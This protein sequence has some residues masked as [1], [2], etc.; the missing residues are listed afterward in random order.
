MP[1]KVFIKRHIRKAMSN[2]R[3]QCWKNSAIWPKRAGVLSGET[4]INH[5]DPRSITVVSSWKTIEDWICWQ[6]SDKRAGNE[7]KIEPCWRSPQNT[8]FTISV[9]LG[10][11]PGVILQLPVPMTSADRSPDTRDR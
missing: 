11:G 6:S 9:H 2:R 5:Y 10:K 3:S 8:K 7:A 1:I 4:L